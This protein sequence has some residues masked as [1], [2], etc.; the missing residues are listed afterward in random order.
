MACLNPIT[1]VDPSACNKALPPR[2]QRLIKVP[3]RHCEECKNSI[4]NSMYVRASFEYKNCMTHNG[5][6]LFCTWTFADKFIPVKFGQYC[7]DKK[8]M[9]R[10]LNK[11]NTYLKRKFAYS[12][13]YMVF[14]ECGHVG[15]HRPHHHGLFFIYPESGLNVSKVITNNRPMFQCS[16]WNI[17]NVIRLVSQ[18]WPYGMVDI[19]EVDPSKGGI[20]YV[21]KYCAKDVEEEN[22][23]RDIVTKVRMR[24]NKRLTDDSVASYYDNHIADSLR[25]FC[26]VIFV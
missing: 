2:L 26:D 25:Y 5:I 6:A 9:Q 13:K 22:V 3:C 11:C 15:T 4:R 24:Y 18:L 10:Y 20:K 14:S 19:R 17:T 21:T 7:F 8:L 1:I 12:L 23:L 16:T